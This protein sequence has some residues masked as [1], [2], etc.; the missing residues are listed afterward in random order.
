M[1][2][3]YTCETPFG[4]FDDC[5][6]GRSTYSFGGRLAIQLFSNSEGPIAVIS[7]N[8]PDERLTDLNCFFVDTN[9]C[10]NWVTDFLEKNNIA[11]PTGEVGFSGYCVYPEYKLTEGFIKENM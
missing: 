6:I 1:K 4:T 9:N 5:V 7:V 10:G 3:N 2:K 8:I 11:V